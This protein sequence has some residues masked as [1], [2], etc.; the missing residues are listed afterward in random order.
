MLD[1]P[2]EAIR[3]LTNGRWLGDRGIFRDW[4]PDAVD[5]ELNGEE[6]VSS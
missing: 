5:V 4:I 2:T 1:Q 3:E 6:C